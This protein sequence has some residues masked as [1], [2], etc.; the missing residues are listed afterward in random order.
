[1]EM[2]PPNNIPISR[3]NS[4]R[5]GRLGSNQNAQ[6]MSQSQRS[7]AASV[8]QDDDGLFW[9]DNDVNED[10]RWDTAEDREEEDALGW[11]SGLQHEVCAFTTYTSM[12]T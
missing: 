1:M 11:A 10:R 2:P 4:S 6:P 3:L 8:P 9:P 12:R 7:A 5:G